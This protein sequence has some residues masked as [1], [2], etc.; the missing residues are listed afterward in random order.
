MP[1]WCIPIF[2]LIILVFAHIMRWED[3]PRKTF[4]YYI[5]QYEHDRW[6]NQDWL[7]TYSLDKINYK[8][9]NDPAGFGEEARKVV[10][11]IWAGLLSYAVFLL[12][13]LIKPPEKLWGNI[14]Y[15]VFGLLTSYLI[16][17]F[18]ATIAS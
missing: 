13:W 11:K 8:L 7:K 16:G 12:K 15:I 5:I 1:K 2:I 10:S 14:V 18:Y 6:L 4:G 9:I 3:G 17:G